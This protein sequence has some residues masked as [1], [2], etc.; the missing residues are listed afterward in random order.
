VQ[1]QLNY[2]R[3]QL[4]LANNLGTLKEQLVTLA[5]EGS[6]LLAENKTRPSMGTKLNPLPPSSLRAKAPT[7]F[8]K[9]VVE[10]PPAIEAE[11]AEEG[12]EEQPQAVVAEPSSSAYASEDRE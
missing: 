11:T 10:Q 2:K 12:V 5:S 3:S 6:P 8:N 1:Q 4:K 9:P 7:S